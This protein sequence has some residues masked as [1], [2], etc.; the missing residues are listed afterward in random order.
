MKKMPLGAAGF[1]IKLIR[2]IVKVSP[3]PDKVFG[4]F[5]VFFL[6]FAIIL[7]LWVINR[8]SVLLCN[9]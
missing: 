5:A 4:L 7:D 3:G 2:H 8:L 6:N 9:K 1:E